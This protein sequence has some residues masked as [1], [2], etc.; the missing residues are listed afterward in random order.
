MDVSIV[1]PY[2]KRKEMF[3]N[4][5]HSIVEND[6][7]LTDYEVIVVEDGTHDFCQKS[8]QEISRNI[9]YEN[10]GKRESDE[11]RTPPRN[12]GVKRAVGE[13]IIFLDC[14]QIVNADFV[15]QHVMF[16][17]KQASPIVQLGTRRNL[18]CQANLG[19]ID[20]EPYE[21]DVRLRIFSEYRCDGSGLLGIWALCW[22]HNISI[23]K[24][25]LDQHGGFDDEFVHWG[26]EDV[27]LGY[28]MH[29]ANVKIL[30]NPLVEV[31]HQY[32]PPAYGARV[33][34]GWLKNFNLFRDKYPDDYEVEALRVVADIIDPTYTIRLK[35]SHILDASALHYKRFETMLRCFCRAVDRK[36]MSVFPL[37]NFTYRS[38]VKRPGLSV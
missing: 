26:L 14:D 15:R 4:Q 19:R 12:I 27:E 25:L 7:S 37:E 30:H 24:V 28:R 1:I 3:L 21:E 13:I 33:Y 35:K 34:R 29:K 17:R 31:Y 10:S 6:Y 22:S 23:P 9:H 5:I 2:Y 11:K 18:F 20:K 36:D 38:R 8:L 32:H 16:H